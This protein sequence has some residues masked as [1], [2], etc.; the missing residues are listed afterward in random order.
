MFPW[1]LV[2]DQCQYFAAN[3]GGTVGV[4]W[5]K[6]WYC[7]LGRMQYP[8]IVFFYGHKDPITF[9]HVILCLFQCWNANSSD[10]LCRLSSNQ[11]AVISHCF[12]WLQSIFAFTGHKIQKLYFL[13]FFKNHWVLHQPCSLSSISIMNEMNCVS[14]RNC[15]WKQFPPKWMG[16]M[17]RDRYVLF[18]MSCDIC[19][20][21]ESM[22]YC[23]LK[24]GSQVLTVRCFPS[25]KTRIS[26]DL[27]ICNK[28]GWSP[29]VVFWLQILCLHAKLRAHQKLFCSSA[30]VSPHLQGLCL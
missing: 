8:G 28:M 30:A 29:S 25:G 19:M 20:E 21:W 6:W 26:E 13:A 27:G 10:L 16:A 12:G 4:F 9:F 5:K 23:L 17:N 14:V 24:C 18:H 22:L 2:L 11:T 15:T 3:L 7:L 1:A